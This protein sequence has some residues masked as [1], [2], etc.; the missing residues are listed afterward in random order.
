MLLR[1]KYALFLCVKMD[2]DKTSLRAEKQT[3]FPCLPE[4]HSSTPA[5]NSHLQ[6]PLHRAHQPYILL[7]TWPDLSHHW[8]RNQGSEHSNGI[9]D[10]NNPEIARPLTEKSRKNTCWLNITCV[11]RRSEAKFLKGFKVQRREHVKVRT[12]HHTR[13]RC[14]SAL[15]KCFSTGH[16]TYL[17]SLE[18]WLLHLPPAQSWK[19]LCTPGSCCCILVYECFA[20]RNTTNWKWFLLFSFSPSFFS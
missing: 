2:A 14:C 19:G 6:G 7:L 12:A 10:N 8:S 3:I 17:S 1:P 20:R 16:A 9:N 4:T 5:H 11:A 18:C 15:L 13:P